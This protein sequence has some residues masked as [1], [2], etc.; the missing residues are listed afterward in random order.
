[1]VL[2]ADFTGRRPGLSSELERRRRSLRVDLRRRVIRSGA[3]GPQE[4]AAVLDIH[5]DG[6]RM[7][8]AEPVPTAAVF[9]CTFAPDPNR[10]TA[11]VLSSHAQRPDGHDGG[12]VT[13]LEFDG[14][15][16]AA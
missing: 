3:S 5:P 11:R 2:V 7:A 15:P 8:T 4:D 16:D 6:F 9:V 13:E 1:M 12:Y 14:G 10:S